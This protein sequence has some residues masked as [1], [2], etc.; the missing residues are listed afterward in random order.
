MSLDLK[1]L[2]GQTFGLK[3]DGSNALVLVYGN[4]D[5]T[6]TVC[7]HDEVVKLMLLY[8]G[9]LIDIDALVRQ[10]ILGETP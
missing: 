1:E 7:T 9:G 4:N 6:V 3:F 8:R 5:R 2:Q 10:S